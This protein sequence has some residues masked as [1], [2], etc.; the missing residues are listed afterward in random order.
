MY[1]TT[2]QQSTRSYPLLNGA[3]YIAHMVADL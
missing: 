3:L 1:I 2:D